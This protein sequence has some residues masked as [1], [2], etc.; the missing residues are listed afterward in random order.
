M[1]YWGHRYNIF[2]FLDNNTFEHTE[3]RYECLT[4]AGAVHIY[5]K[6]IFIK[7]MLREEKDWL[8]GH[9]SYDF[10]N[11]LENLHSGHT[12]RFAFGELGFFR[13]DTVCFIPRGSNRIHIESINPEPETIETEIRNVIL[14][15]AA[16]TI[17]GVS[18]QKRLSH[19]DYLTRVRQLQ[20]HIREG[21]CYEVNFC[22]EA[23]AEN[24]NIDPLAVFEQLN[25]LSK[26]PFAAC[27]KNREQYLMCASPER[28]LYKTGTRILAQPIKGT[29]RRGSSAD[30]DEKQKK[31]LKESIK[32]KA[33]NVMIVDLM[34]N[35]LARFCQTGS[36]E[37]PELFGIYSFE[38]VHQM[39]SSISGT[40]LPDADLWEMIC[41]SF[42]MG[43]MT[44]APKI[45]VMELIEL[46]ENARR[47]LFSGTVGYFNPD[48]DFD[49]NVIIRSLFYNKA[50]HYLSYQTGGAITAD[51][52][53]EEE[54]QET[55]LKASAFGKIFNNN[56]IPSSTT[57][58]PQ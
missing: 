52:D 32:E 45:K 57:V 39:I 42:P 46:Y 34:R 54:W 18:F 33:E 55:L 3:G 56:T 7:E 53:P 49:F 26:A 29:A 58:S 11:R 31:R 15:E 28:Y 38:Q 43:S 48:G 16:P 8:L 20:Q 1:L 41:L 4:G 36:V 6:E 24:C 14:P 17:P 35:D 25:T 23:Y 12:S 51:S 5:E 21:D 2:L 10:K 47:E 19:K 50:C 44:G 9:I 40:V 22:N 27:Y 13:P 37:V 30:E